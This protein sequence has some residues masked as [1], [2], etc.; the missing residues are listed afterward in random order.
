MGTDVI[1]QAKSGMGKTAVFVLSVLQQ[2]EPNPPPASVLVLC[3]TRELAYQ[4]CNEFDRFKKY[5]PAIKTAVFY[6][7]LPVQAHRDVLKTEQPHIIIGTTGRVLQLAM[8]KDLNF[9]NVKHFIL[10]E[11]D[12][13]LESL[14]MRKDVQQIFRLTPHDKQ[15][16]M[17]TATL[18]DE[19]RLLCKKFMHNVSIFPFIF[20]HI[21]RFICLGGINSHN[22]TLSFFVENF[23]GFF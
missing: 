9:K 11:C 1:C 19:M 20:L 17:F 5:L 15:V 14:D 21:L 2:L 13:M 3:H 4:I 12:K 6:G 8:E 23:V 22:S 18:S 16:M 10:D 7:G